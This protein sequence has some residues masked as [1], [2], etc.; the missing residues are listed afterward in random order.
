MLLLAICEANLKPTMET[1]AIVAKI[2]G[3]GITPSAVRCARLCADFL[4]VADSHSI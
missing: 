2:L 1:W 4:S 3:G